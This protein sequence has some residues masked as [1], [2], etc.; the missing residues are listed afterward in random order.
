MLF[1]PAG[2]GTRAA[3]SGPS[4]LGPL[5]LLPEEI[6]CIHQLEPSGPGGPSGLPSCF[7][8]SRLQLLA[9][10]ARAPRPQE[11]I[12]CIHQPSLSKHEGPAASRGQAPSCTRAESSVEAD[13]R[14]ARSQ[15]NAGHSAAARECVLKQRPVEALIQYFTAEWAVT[16]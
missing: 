13:S 15:L 3:A 12:G 11:S 8:P 6:E 10:G 2:R 16:D 1:R 4:G 7:L 14:A 5:Q 9:A